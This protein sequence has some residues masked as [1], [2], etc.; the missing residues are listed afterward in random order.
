MRFSSVHLASVAYDLPA[1]DG[2]CTSLDLEAELA[3]VYERFALSA[4]RLELMSGIR[5]R[6]HYPPGT[7]PSAIAT[8]AGERALAAAN[9]LGITRDDLGL[10]CF[11][12]VCRDFLE[13][14]S[15]SVVHHN[16]GL[17]AQT[18]S[19]DVSNACLGFAN[20]M[21]LAAQMIESGAMRAA[22]IV[23]GED[24]GPLV[25]RTLSSLL[26]PDTTRKTLKRAMASL[27]IGSG[28]AAMVLAHRDLAPGTPRLTAAVARAATEH[29]EL[30]QGDQVADGLLE[31][32]TDSEALLVA[33]VELAKQTWIDF[34]ADVPFGAHEW[35]RVVTHQ[36]GSAHRRALLQGVNLAAE[37]D[38][39]TVDTLGNIGSVSLPLTYAR[40]C[41]AGFIQPTDRT[42]LLGI[43]SG[44]N[45]LMLAITP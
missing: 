37:I 19:F 2:V 36:V 12:S 43:G 5:E 4:G 34:H 6:R 9:Q 21:V 7:R 30:C 27:T 23:A 39:P 10:M 13:P 44:L 35:Q 14:A 18:T 20:A 45:C 38:F 1:E 16:L 41:E 24:G 40:G 32:T 42:A 8:R 15:A 17:G 3:P 28:G 33:G 29:N 22:L 26:G 31:M 11:S 25:R